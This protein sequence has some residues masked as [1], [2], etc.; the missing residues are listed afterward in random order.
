MLC[1]MW[2][3]FAEG[4]DVCESGG[5]WAGAGAGEED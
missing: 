1:G 4:T 2:V 5:E 3:C